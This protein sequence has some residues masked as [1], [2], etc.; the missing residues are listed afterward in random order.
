MG[1]QFLPVDPALPALIEATRPDG[2]RLVT[3][4]IP[5]CQNDATL[6]Q[7]RSE[8]LHY[9]PGRRGVLKFTVRLSRVDIKPHQRVVFG[10]LFADDRG[11]ESTVTCKL[12]GKCRAVRLPPHTRAVGL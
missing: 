8:L 6:E 4:F 10:K 3:P 2:G 5:E 12:C 1:I 7:T 11:A 9:K